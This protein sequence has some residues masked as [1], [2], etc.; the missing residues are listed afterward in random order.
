MELYTQA[1]MGRKRILPMLS[2]HGQGLV[3]LAAVFSPHSKSVGR[4]CAPSFSA[5]V[6]L[7]EHGAPVQERA[8]FFA[9]TTAT[10]MNSTELATPT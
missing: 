5:H 7:G 2:L 6:R 3:L 9:P 4:G 8:S 1:Y 10:P